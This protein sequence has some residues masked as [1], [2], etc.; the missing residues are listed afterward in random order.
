MSRNAKGRLIH[1]KISYCK[2]LVRVSVLAKLLFTWMI[3]NTDDLGRMEGEPEVIKGMIFPYEDFTID[4]IYAALKELS[5][6]KLIL[7]YEVDGNRYIQFPNFNKYQTLRRDREH[8]SDIPPYSAV[9]IPMTDN[10]SHW[11]ANDIPTA[12]IGMPMAT[13]DGQCH[14]EEKENKKRIRIRS[15]V[16][17]E[18]KK[19]DGGE[20]P[21]SLDLQAKDLCEYY[22]KLK[23]GQSITAHF[24]YMKIKIDMYGYD[25]V[26]EAMQK[27]ISS[28]G[29]FV[30]AWMDKVLKSWQNEGRVEDGATGANGEPTESN[31]REGIGFSV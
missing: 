21:L 6:E 26:K 12:D 29:K 18:E 23:P 24:D 25:W 7:W 16:E 9:G 4:Q 3:P 19:K 2:Q 22:E 15:E 20:P 11:Y 13:N 10:D 27:C 14:P 1:R 5:D 28:T 17:E 8:I 31:D 30:T